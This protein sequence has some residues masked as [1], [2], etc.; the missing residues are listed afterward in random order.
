MLPIDL[1]CWVGLLFI[2]DL[3]VCVKFCFGLDICGWVF[4]YTGVCCIVSLDVCW[5]FGDFC[6][7]VVLV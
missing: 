4:G 3:V 6:G 2:V 7:F 5:V 1:V